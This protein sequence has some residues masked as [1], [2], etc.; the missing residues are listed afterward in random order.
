MKPEAVHRV[1]CYHEAGR[2]VV[3]ILLANVSSR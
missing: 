3:A 2:A 1:V